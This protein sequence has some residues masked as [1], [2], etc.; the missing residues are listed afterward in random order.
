MTYR[1]TLEYRLPPKEKQYKIY[2]ISAAN[3][4]GQYVADTFLSFFAIEL[5]GSYTQLSIISSIR[6]LGNSILT[7]FWGTQSDKNGRK[8]YLVLGNLALLL[9][10]ISFFFISKMTSLIT[11]L[12]IQSLIGSAAIPV[13]ISTLGDF[14]KTKTRG[15]FIGKVTGFGTFL[16]IITILIAGNWMDRSGL[17]GPNQY[18]LAFVLS[19]FCFVLAIILIFSLKESLTGEKI[20][21]KPSSIL[22][23]LR[24]NLVY[25]RFVIIESVFFFGMSLVWPIFSFVTKNI[26]QATN[27]Q[28]SAITTAN[29]VS[30]AIAMRVAGTVSDKIGRKP[31]LISGRMILFIVPLLYALTGIWPNWI[32]LLVAGFLGG[33]SVGLVIPTKNAIALDLAPKKHRASFLGIFVMITGITSF[34]GSLVGGSLT[35]LLSLSIGDANA[36]VLVMYLGALIRFLTSFGYFFLKETAPAKISHLNGFSNI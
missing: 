6:N 15:A 25:R 34:A 27:A 14:S 23:I 32:L 33:I 28:I 4:S 3:S 20:S 24:K 7:S 30:M 22:Y 11:I 19:S 1:D 35:Q 8:P 21:E 5:G 2:G 10:V 16:S 31:V 17:K 9:S 13:W 18:R 29:M 26:V 12:I 36:L